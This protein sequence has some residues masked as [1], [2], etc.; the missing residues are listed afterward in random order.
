[1]V[2]EI[3]KMGT[4]RVAVPPHGLI[5][6]GNEAYR[7]QEAF[8]SVP[9]PPGPQKLTKNVKKRKNVTNPMFAVFFAVFVPLKGT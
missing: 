8:G 7:L 2:R 4:I 3:M 1:M 9:G 6:G 5:F